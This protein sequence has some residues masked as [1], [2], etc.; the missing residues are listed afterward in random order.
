MKAGSTDKTEFK[1]STSRQ[2]L[3]SA[4]SQTL[5]RHNFRAIV[6]NGF[7]LIEF[8]IYCIYKLVLNGNLKLCVSNHDARNQID[9][10]NNTTHN[11]Q[12]ATQTADNNDGEIMVFG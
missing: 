2:N 10:R 3:H 11:V 6:Y 9:N 4:G 7:V 1:Q 8:E 12:R 5:H